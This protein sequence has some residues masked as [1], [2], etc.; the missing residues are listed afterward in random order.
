MQYWRA[1]EQRNHR[2]R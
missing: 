2:H 1:G